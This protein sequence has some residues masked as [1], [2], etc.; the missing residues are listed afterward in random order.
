MPFMPLALQT[1]AQRCYHHL[2]NTRRGRSQ[3]ASAVHVVFITLLRPSISNSIMI[4]ASPSC[5]TLPVFFLSFAFENQVWCMLFT[6]FI[7]MIPSRLLSFILL[8]SSFSF[9]LFSPRVAESPLGDQEN[10]LTTR[11]RKMTVFK[12]DGFK[13]IISIVDNMLRCSMGG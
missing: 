4:V 8:L 13:K 5:V 3:P 7:K 11:M 1:T 9:S 10:S 12:D 2:F 6:C